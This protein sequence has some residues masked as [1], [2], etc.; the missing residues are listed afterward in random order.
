MDDFIGNF[1]NLQDSL[2]FRLKSVNY[3]RKTLI[4]DVWQASEYTSDPL[5]FLFKQ[6]SFVLYEGV[7]WHYIN[8]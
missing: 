8:F 4:L 7:F 6:F 1:W 2:F 5:Q 3:F